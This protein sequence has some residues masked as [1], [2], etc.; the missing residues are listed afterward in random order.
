MLCPNCGWGWATSYFDPIVTDQTEYKIILLEGND[1][2]VEKIRAVNRVSHR[3]LLKSKEL[4]ADAPQ[5]IF[6]GDAI[7]VHDKKEILEEEQVLYKIEP[8][9]PYD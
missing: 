6:E 7:E 4:I 9:Y 8:D 5:V 1:A 2:S 3:N